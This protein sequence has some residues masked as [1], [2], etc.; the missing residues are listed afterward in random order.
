[1]NTVFG[2]IPFGHL[3]R[4]QLS[5]R[6]LLVLAMVLLASGC[7]TQPTLDVY[8]T[9]IVPL[10][11]SGLLEQRARMDLR[12]QNLSE[13]P[14]Q[15]TGVDVRVVVNGTQLARGVSG[16]GFEIPRLDSVST[17]V[18]VSASAFATI[19]Q[20]LGIANR[21]R[22]SY[23]LKGRVFTEGVDKR[24]TRAGEF[25]REEL[26]NLALPSGARSSDGKTGG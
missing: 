4:F 21:T 8:V 14:V 20:L 6:K 23:Q 16:A 12:L 18:E 1:M 19:R 13:T 17:S 2:T 11:S 25:T 26:S 7:V 15:A 10:A 22:F 24:F 5:V 9:N 3:A